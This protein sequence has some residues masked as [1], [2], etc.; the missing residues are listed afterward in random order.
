MLAKKYRLPIQNFFTKPAESRRTNYFLLKSFG[1]RE[2]R[3]RFGV[4]ISKKVF[5]K[6]TGRNRLRRTVFSFL[7]L[8]QAQLPVKDFLIIV[9]PAVA[10][11][12]KEKTLQELKKIFNL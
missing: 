8:H 7:E 11:L 9:S 3:S 2:R 5:S 12:D 6:P 1:P 10:K 4:V